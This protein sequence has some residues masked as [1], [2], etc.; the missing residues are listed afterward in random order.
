MTILDMHCSFYPVCGCDGGEYCA[1]AAA[2]GRG[3]WRARATAW[4]AAAKRSRTRLIACAEIML[5][6]CAVVDRLTAALA[7]SKARPHMRDMQNQLAKARA[8]LD[9]VK[10]TKA[11]YHDRM[12]ENG[13]TVDQR[14]ETIQD[15]RSTL[16]STQGL[17]EGLQARLDTADLANERL[18]A[19]CRERFD[20]LATLRRLLIS[21]TPRKEGA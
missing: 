12:V 18:T 17:A 15:L 16:A 14:N 20:E 11:F 21:G 9:A 7:E 13:R 10:E 5:D 1:P 4:K 19:I 6:Q 3:W 2:S 8:D